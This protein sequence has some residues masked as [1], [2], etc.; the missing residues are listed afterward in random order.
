MILA[1]AAVHTHLVRQS[2]RTFTSLN[3]RC[4]ECLDVH[5]F[6][7]LIGVGATTVNAY[8]AQESIA[9]RQRARP[10][11]QPVAEGGGAALQEGGRQGPAEGDVEDRHLRA[12]L[13]SRRLQFR[14]DR[15][16]ARAG[17]RV[18]PRH[19]V[20][21]QRHRPVPASPARCSA[22]TSPPGTREATT[23]PVGGVYKLRQRG[24]VHAF[25]GKLIHTLQSAVAT[26]SFE[27]Y[28]RYA[29]AVRRQKPVALRDLLDFRT[30]RG[31]RRSR[32]TRSRASPRSASACWRPASRS[33]RSAPRR[34]RRCQHR[35]EPDRRPQ[36]QRRGR[37]GPGARQAA[38]ERRQRQL[39]DQADRLRP[40]RR[41][42]R[43][44]EQLPRD[45]DQGRPGRQARRGRPAARASRS[46]G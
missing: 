10:V 9:D 36:R 43:V 22:C 3:V 30:R 2:L 41:D 6:A 16:V 40:L 34:T 45:R 33:A 29:D 23:L 14:G 15:P 32:S 12:L 5:Y 21:H 27:T 8:L 28:R 18:L 20:A 17:R 11:R 42:G 13:L 39:R 35:H 7:V 38:P 44:P 25:E 19:A 24:E 4:A 31:R 37:R 46:P 1:T 26:D